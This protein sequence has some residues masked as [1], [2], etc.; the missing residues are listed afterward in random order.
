MH[1]RRNGDGARVRSAAAQGG[2]VVIAVDTLEARY[3]D[4]VLL[5]PAPCGYGQAL[6]A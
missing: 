2:H 3:D 1:Y 4:D 5:Y 6:R